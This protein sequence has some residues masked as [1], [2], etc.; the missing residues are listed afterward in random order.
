MQDTANTHLIMPVIGLTCASCVNRLEKSLNR[1]AE[2]KQAS[3]NLA[4]ETL[5]IMF[6]SNTPIDTIP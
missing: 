3:V 2:V 6:D 4:L 5:D 1:R